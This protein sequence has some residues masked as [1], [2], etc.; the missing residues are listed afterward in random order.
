[1]FEGCASNLQDMKVL[2]RSPGQYRV[3]SI[4][5]PASIDYQSMLSSFALTQKKVTEEKVK[6][7]EKFHQKPTLRSLRMVNSVVP[8]T[9]QS[10]DDLKQYHPRSLA[11]LVLWRNFS[12][13]ISTP[14]A[15]VDRRVLPE[16]VH[17]P[18]CI[19]AKPWVLRWR[20]QETSHFCRC[21]YM[22]GRH[23]ALWREVRCSAHNR[24]WNCCRREPRAPV[25]AAGRV[26]PRRACTRRV[27]RRYSGGQRYRRCPS[28]RQNAG[29]TH[30]TT[31]AAISR[32][33]GRC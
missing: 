28:R 33:R 6:T 4:D 8:T 29:R 5:D 30:A 27:N 3:V 1:V 18:L 14:V 2:H 23:V 20:N 10:R 32:T 11:P 25:V 21:G 17:A 19:S 7:V 26:K 13:V 12:K 24:N 15:S 22:R 31:P 9:T 16:Y